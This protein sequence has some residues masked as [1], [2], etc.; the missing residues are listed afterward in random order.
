MFRGS[1]EDLDAPGSVVRI[2]D[3][4]QTLEQA[5]RTLATD[6]EDAT[7]RTMCRA[8][9]TDIGNAIVAARDEDTQ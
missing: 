6:S 1:V 5:G 8:R 2:V 7:S 3:G 4:K 9:E